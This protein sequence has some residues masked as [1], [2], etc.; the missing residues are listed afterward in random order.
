LRWFCKTAHLDLKEQEGQIEDLQQQIH[1]L[2]KLVIQS[3]QREEE[4]WKQLMDAHC[5]PV[6]S[7]QD[8]SMVHGHAK[9]KESRVPT[10]SDVNTK[11]KIKPSE[12]T[13]FQR[14]SS[15]LPTE[16]LVKQ[17]MTGNYV[18]EPGDGDSDPD[19]DSD[20]SNNNDYSLSDSDDEVKPM[21][22]PRP[23]GS[24]PLTNEIV[25][26]FE[27]DFLALE[28]ELDHDSNTTVYFT[29]KQQLLTTP[30][31]MFLLS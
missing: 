5:A 21:S 6:M 31:E 14:M 19:P 13:Q 10:E 1:D 25:G 3:Q 24:S 16:S 7:T 17:A 29:Q 27:V 28:P 15:V 2:E 9:V 4:T 8:P 12:N 18:N 26:D 11:P 23:R 20:T 22:Q 30:L